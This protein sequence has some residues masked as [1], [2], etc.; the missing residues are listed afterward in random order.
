ML[1]LD[2]FL[3][4]LIGRIL[5]DVEVGW[6]PMWDCI[7]LA[8]IRAA[9][10]DILKE[11]QRHPE[12]A[13]KFVREVALGLKQRYDDTLLRDERAVWALEVAL[14]YERVLVHLNSRLSSAQSEYCHKQVVSWVRIAAVQDVAYVRRQFQQEAS[15]RPGLAR[16]LDTHTRLQTYVAD[17]PRDHQVNLSELTPPP[18]K[19]W[20]MKSPVLNRK[21]TARLVQVEELTPIRS[22]V[23]PAA[24]P[25]PPVHT[26][27]G[28][29]QTEDDYDLD[30]PLSHIYHRDFAQ[31]FRG[32]EVEAIKAWNYALWLYP[33]LEYRIEA[34]KVLIDCAGKHGGATGCLSQAEDALDVLEQEFP[35]LRGEQRSTVI[36]CRRRLEQLQQNANKFAELSEC[37]SCGRTA[38]PLG[39]CP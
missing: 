20:A 11:A 13:W 31:S 18:P 24:P 32:H 5:N 35:Q 3:T 27:R 38:F 28:Y 22:R 7:T 6:D 2:D 33:R 25:T 14:W 10:G 16:L 15:S 23:S 39:C 29:A 36:Q 12:S 26:N 4:L 34:C 17:R 30:Y 1:G 9:A 21:G 19:F 37:Q 8:G